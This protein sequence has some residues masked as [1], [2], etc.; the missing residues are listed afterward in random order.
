MNESHERFKKEMAK[1]PQSVKRLIE[2]L[3]ASA[4]HEKELLFKQG[5][6]QADIDRARAI[7]REA[8]ED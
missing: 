5:Y 6:T 3:K 1:D 2:T 8:N 4:E 7:V